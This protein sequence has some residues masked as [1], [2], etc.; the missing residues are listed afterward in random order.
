MNEASKLYNIDDNSY[1]R[2]NKDDAWEEEEYGVLC[3]K[4]QGEE[5]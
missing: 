2:K 5:W 3:G 1:R 4:K